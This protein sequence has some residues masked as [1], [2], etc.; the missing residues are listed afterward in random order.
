L[1]ARRISTKYGPGSDVQTVKMRYDYK[2]N[3][4]AVE[5]DFYYSVTTTR[6]P[7]VGRVIVDWTTDDCSFRAE[8]G[9]LDQ[10]M[11]LLILIYS[12]ARENLQWALRGQPAQPAAYRQLRS[13]KRRG[14][15]PVGCTTGA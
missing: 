6:I 8:Q 9:K 14:R 12:S 5:E 10:T 2:L 13:A 7:T 15:D 4:K 3:G 11:P 1:Y